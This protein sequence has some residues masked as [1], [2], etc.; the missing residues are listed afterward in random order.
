[1]A[2]INEYREKYENQKDELLKV[3]ISINLLISLKNIIIIVQ[4]GINEIAGSKEY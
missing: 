4:V 1:M 3:D 2:R